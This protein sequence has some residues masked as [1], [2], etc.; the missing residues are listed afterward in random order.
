MGWE[1]PLGEDALSETSLVVL[2]VG[3]EAFS[4]EGSPG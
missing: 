1:V 4:A 3:A 2:E